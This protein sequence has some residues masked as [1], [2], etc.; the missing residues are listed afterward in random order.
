MLLFSLLILCFSSHIGARE[1]IPPLCN[2]GDNLLVYEGDVNFLLNGT[3]SNDPDNGP[4]PLQYKW[5]QIMGPV[6]RNL[7]TFIE[8]HKFSPLLEVPSSKLD[9]GVYVFRLYV[10]DGISITQ[11]D[12]QIYIAPD[13]VKLE[14]VGRESAAERRELVAIQFFIVMWFAFIALVFR[15][16]Y[17]RVTNK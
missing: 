3:G 10:S 15:Y 13:L 1:N 12:T 6:N 17:M 5:Q 8:A 11:C 2:A 9:I 14:V 16:L 4:F 7:D